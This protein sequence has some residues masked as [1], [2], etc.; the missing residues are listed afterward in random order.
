M[1]K[2]LTCIAICSFGILSA[3][4]SEEYHKLKKKFPESHSVTLNEEVAIS[5]N[6]VEGKLQIEESTANEHIYLSKFA[7]FGAKQEIGFSSFSEIK[8]IKAATYVFKEKKYIKNTVKEFIESDDVGQNFYDDS[9]KI[10]FFFKGLGEG[11]KTQKSYIRKIKNPR[12]LNAH[13]FG[14]RHPILKNKFTVT[15]DNSIDMEFKKFGFENVE[16]LEYSKKVN[17]KNTTH[18]WFLKDS[19]KIDLESN[20]PNFRKRL[21]NI[22]PIIK[23]YKYKNKVIEVSGSVKNLYDW[24]YSLVE[25]VNEENQNEELK[26]LVLDLTKDK[27]N[28][29][30]KV[31]AIYYWV[32]ENIKYI[33]FEYALG[34]FVPR[35][36][37]EV[38]SRKYGDCKDN[39]SILQ[40]MLKTAD[41]QGHL[42]WIGTRDIPFTYNELPTPAVDNHMILS[43]ISKENNIYF[44]DATGR[45]LSLDMPSS[46]IQGKE[47]LIGLDKG[48]YRI[49]KVPFVPSI[50]NVYKDSVYLKLKDKKIIGSGELKLMG[51]PKID[52]FNAL[53]RVK[54]DKGKQDFYN[55]NL[56]KGSNRFL[57]DDFQEKNKY[58]YDTPFVV[59]YKFNIDNYTK[60]YE[61]EVYINLNV[62]SG[63]DNFKTSETRKSGKNYRYKS[64]SQLKAVLDIPADMEV[65]FIPENYTY[66]EANFECKIEYSKVSENQ[67][68]LSFIIIQDFTTLNLEEQKKMNKVVSEIKKKQKDVVV[69]KK[70]NS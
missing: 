26:Q 55:T 14:E 15:V 58:G 33:A 56:R 38:Y 37:N 20:A 4:F 7:N 3:Q 11:V 23:S 64:N 52:F 43:Y 63:I 59:D 34:G 51:Y 35:R 22:I 69:L 44:L 21:P 32:Q 16:N 29:I 6:L 66:K 62:F 31:K 39:S 50:K 47:A 42:T 28:D 27:E 24:Y 5:I 54:T 41:L 68:V 57:I 61:N 12:F 60:G 65:S 17:K 25:N 1:K 46:F 10:S 9:K 67:L 18:T 45:Y 48:D 49:E 8:D 36:A 2:I 30:D 40:E 70:K 13:F 19:K 53:E